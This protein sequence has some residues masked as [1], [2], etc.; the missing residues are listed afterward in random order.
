MKQR[1]TTSS[2]KWTIWNHD[3]I[4]C[5]LSVVS[6][7]LLLSICLS[8]LIYVKGESDLICLPWWEVLSHFEGRTCIKGV[9]VSRRLK[10]RMSRCFLLWVVVVLGSNIGSDTSFRF[11]K[12][13]QANTVLSEIKLQSLR[14]SFFTSLLTNY[15]SFRLN[16]IGNTDGILKY[17]INEW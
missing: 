3:F 6:Y 8:R 17:F 2:L 12:R 14:A 7:T 16:V 15:F 4:L 1:K 10:Q 5:N 13:F 9:W 11:L